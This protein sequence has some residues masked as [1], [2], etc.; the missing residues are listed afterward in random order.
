MGRAPARVNARRRKKERQKSRLQQ[1]AV[2][3]VAGECAGSGNKR[4]KATQQT[5]KL[6]RG[7]RLKK[8][9]TDA[10]RPIQVMV[11]SAASLDEIQ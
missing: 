1:H 7:Q 9:T 5:K 6:S 4:E 8:A 2:G 11:I 10:T 3:L